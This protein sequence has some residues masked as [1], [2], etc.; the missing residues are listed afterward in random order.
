M[1]PLMLKMY[2][3]RLGDAGAPLQPRIDSE[4][5]NHLGYVEYSLKGVQFLVDDKFSAADVQMSF[6]GEVAGAFG[7]HSG[8]PNLD[9]WV[10]RLHSRSAYQSAIQRGGPYGMATN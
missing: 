4:I 10:A 7:L 3:G 8:Y 1:L 2:V 9:A 6:V 5:A